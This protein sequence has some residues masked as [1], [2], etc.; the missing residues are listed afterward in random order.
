[1]ETAYDLLRGHPFTG[2]L[3]KEQLTRLSMCAHRAM[4]HSGVRIFRE[5]TPADRFWL[6]RQGHVVL[7]YESPGKRTQEIETLEPG[8]VL[9]WSWMAPP[10]TWH[11]GAVAE[12]DVFA[13]EFNAAEVRRLCT[14]DPE[15]GYE[16]TRRFAQVVVDRLQATRRRLI[17]ATGESTPT[18]PEP[19]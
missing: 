10:F 3:P 19:P 17:D 13:V 15:L 7:D 1:M 16:L 8:S 6:I 9:G 18:P 4:F 11:F 14:A 5:N 12:D 2:D